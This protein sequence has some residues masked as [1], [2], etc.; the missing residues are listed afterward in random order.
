MKKENVLFLILDFK[1]SK[2]NTQSESHLISVLVIRICNISG[3][4]FK[5]EIISLYYTL[6]C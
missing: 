1:D 5:S 4:S 6:K 2:K 3:K